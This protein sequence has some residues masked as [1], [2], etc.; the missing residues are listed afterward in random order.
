M[1]FRVGEKSSIVS[2][3]FSR[4]KMKNV[5]QKAFFT[6]ALFSLFCKPGDLHVAQSRE[7]SVVCFEKPCNG[8]SAR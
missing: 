2:C 5:S 6:R 1:K 8:K 7:A 4:L 3:D